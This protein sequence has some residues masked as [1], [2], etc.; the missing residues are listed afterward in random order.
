M[1][2]TLE[3]PYLHRMYNRSFCT[4]LVIFVLGL[5]SCNQV[6]ARKA[7]AV[8]DEIIAGHRHV[9]QA[10]EG[11]IGVL[12]EKDRTEIEAA[13]DDLQ[14][15]TR[16]GLQTLQTIEPP[17]CD[18]GFLDAT[19]EMYAFYDEASTSDYRTIARFYALDS[20]TYEQYDSLQLLIEAIEERQAEIEAQ[21]VA[22]Q[23]SFAQSCGFKLVRNVD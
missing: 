12:D 10:M 16:E 21:F 18:N 4:L 15:V 20:I 14:Q 17:K 6:D 22:A 2:S 8:N 19:A 7:V 1:A 23:S 11:F 3:M 5:T 13:L 9:V